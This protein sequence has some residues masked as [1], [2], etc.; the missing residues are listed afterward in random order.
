MKDIDNAS[1]ILDLISDPAFCV[2]DNEILCV[3]RN[4]Q[5]LG[6]QTGTNVL[7]LLGN[8]KE[9]YEQYSGGTL[10]LSL[11]IFP[12]EIG[13]TVTCL[14]KLQI[15]KLDASSMNDS[16]Q[17]MAL[18][19]QYLRMPLSD[20]I[21]ISDRM[22][23][24]EDN[25][26]EAMHFKRSL[27]RMQRLLNNMSCS[28][29]ILPDTLNAMEVLDVAALFREL[30]EKA[31]ATVTKS[32]RTLQYTGPEDAILT[33]ANRERLEQAMF[34]L[35]SNAI[36]FSPVK[37]QI[38]LSL[39]RRNSSLI[40]TVTNENDGRTPINTEDIFARFLRM[41]SV[42]EGRVGLGLGMLIVRSVAM[43]HGGT[44]LV[45]S[46]KTTKV[47]MTLA[48]RKGGTETLRSKILPINISG[49]MDPVLTEFAEVL[50]AEEFK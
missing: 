48:I 20:L 45:E 39:A 7:E 25:S 22:L 31:E 16:L 1:K 2:Q 40:F 8:N 32:G 26:P 44:V 5:S 12:K 10:N 43:A 42:D 6:I 33:L 17:A 38:R 47:T 50:P 41:P 9:V 19:S 29:N 3:N 37:S 30:A 21:T 27:Y 28:A 49:G 34:N 4:A 11:T 36:K 18:A 15:F 24:Q 14:D 13:A 23:P 46:S 35:I